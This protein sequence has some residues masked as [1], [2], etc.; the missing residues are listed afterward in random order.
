M[1][2]QEMKRLSISREVPVVGSYDVIV[3]GG[4]PSGIMAAVAAAREGARVALIERYGFVGGMAT[5]GMV[6]PLS[7]FRY[8]GELVIGGIPWELVRRMEA[9]GGAQ[10]EYPLGNVSIRAESFKLEAQRMLLEAG[11]TLYLHAWLSDLKMDED[12]RVTHAVFVSKSGTQALEGRC[13]ID[14][15]G[16]GDLIAMAGVP[17]LAFD[18]PLQPASLEFLIGGVDTDRVEN[19]HHSQQGV[20][21]H[22]LPMQQKLRELARDPANRVPNFGGPWFCWTLT[23]GQ[24][25]VNC[26]RIEANMADE[27]E[28]T[29]AECVLREDVHRMVELMREHFEPFREAYL[30]ATAAQA[31]VRETRH[32]KGTHVLTGAEYLNAE[33]FPDAI[34]RGCHPLDIHAPNPADQRCQFLK[35]PAYIPYRCLY[36]PDYP[37]LLV[38]GRC[39]SADKEASASIRVMASV[40]GVGQAAGAA[41]A[42]CTRRECAVSEV[43]VP[44]LRARLIEWGAVLGDVSQG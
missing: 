15:T 27:R 43:D 2:N 12:G 5:A 25:V 34:G 23:P 36:A 22:L 31:G 37:N 30:I 39:L 33:P 1:E 9:A 41:A 7:V 21:Y 26:T 44:A 35:K 38:G 4:G 28:Q 10:I 18:G 17:M 14:C 3:C 40:M 8:N 29:R 11:V 32:M 20:N 13:F 6:N 42:Q 16:D 24:L 19:I